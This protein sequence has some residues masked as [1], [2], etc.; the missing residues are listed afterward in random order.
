MSGHGHH[1]KDYKASKQEIVFLV[2]TFIV[3]ICAGSYLYVIGFAPQFEDMTGQTEEVYEDFVIEGTQYGQT[4]TVASLP[5]FQI[6]ADGAYRYLPAGA[7]ENDIDAI[8]GNLPRSLLKELRSVATVD[9]LSRMAE[10]VE[11]ISC[12]SDAGGIDYNYNITINSE[13]YEI[14][15]CTTKLSIDSDVAET[16]DKVWK[17]FETKE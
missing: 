9:A 15:T 11:T 13:N 2:V 14:D 16:L 1:K 4:E 8:E 17:Y 6:L 5:S 12:V 10:T 7:M 3:G